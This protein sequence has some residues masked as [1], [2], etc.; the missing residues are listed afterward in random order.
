MAVQTFSTE[1]DVGHKEPS[2]ALLQAENSTPT[3]RKLAGEDN[4]HDGQEIQRQVVKR[5][6][7]GPFILA[8]ISII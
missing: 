1:M 6:V 4:I 2:S 8:M 7:W 3:Q 5:K